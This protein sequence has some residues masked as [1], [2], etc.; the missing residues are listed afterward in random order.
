MMALIRNETDTERNNTYNATKSQDRQ[1]MTDS[2]K[3]KHTNTN[4]SITD[5]ITPRTLAA[6][7]TISTRVYSAI[8]DLL[9]N[10]HTP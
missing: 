8:L 6:T 1:M 7:Y 2:R 10:A 9:F 5:T 3:C 4:S